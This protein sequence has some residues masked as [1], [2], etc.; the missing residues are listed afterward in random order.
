M[1][2][3]TASSV[4]AKFVTLCSRYNLIHPSIA[5]YQNV[6]E[7][8][9]PKLPA[10]FQRLVNAQYS[11]FTA[12]MMVLLNEAL[13]SGDLN[14][15][16]HRKFFM[17]DRI[18]NA[19]TEG[20]KSVV[21]LGVGYDVLPLLFEHANIQFHLVDRQR[22]PVYQTSNS[23]N[24][25]FIEID[26]NLASSAQELSSKL[27]KEASSVWITEGILDYLKPEAAKKW[28]EHL[29]TQCLTQGARWLSTWFCLEDMS[30]FERWIFLHAVRTVGE[31]IKFMY[32]F[33]IIRHLLNSSN[34][35]SSLHNAAE[36]HQRYPIINTKI[37]NGF[38]LSECYNRRFGKC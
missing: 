2:I 20:Y 7:M 14:H 17:Y 29:K 27:G 30:R 8:L 5:P 36:L 3:S 24:V 9:I 12:K 11:T 4:E 37:M 10:F 25:N 28:I 6:F 19:L 16:L 23:K 32:S 22:S 13:L 35:V 34:L 15:I 21:V 26:L 33:D 38:Y 1:K 31:E 18:Q